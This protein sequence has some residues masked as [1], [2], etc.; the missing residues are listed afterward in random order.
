MALWDIPKKGVEKLG[1]TS[2]GQASK[3]TI[4]GMGKGLIKGSKYAGI[5]AKAGLATASQVAGVGTAGV[6]AG[7]GFV[8]LS[9]ASNPKFGLAMVILFIDFMIFGFNRGAAQLV[10][11]VIMYIVL[12]LIYFAW[13]LIASHGGSLK[14]AIKVFFLSLGISALQMAIPYFVLKYLTLWIPSVAGLIFVITLMFSPWA[15][16]YLFLNP[17]RVPNWVFRFIKIAWVIILMVLLLITLLPT[18]L[19]A[20]SGGVATTTSLSISPGEA[21]TDFKG[22][23][24]EQFESIS[25]KI[26]QLIHGPDLEGARGKIDKNKNSRLGVFIKDQ[27]VLETRVYENKEFT[28][29]G[30]LD[31]NTYFN[32]TEIYMSCYRLKNRDKKTKVVGEMDQIL[33]DVFGRNKEIIECKIPGGEKGIYQNYFEADFDFETWAYIDYT[34]VDRS[35]AMQYYREGRDINKELSIETET[36]PV[37]TDGPVKIL[38]IAAN[39]P[40]EVDFDKEKFPKIGLSLEKNYDR[41]DINLV[42]EIVI[43]TPKLVT[44]KDCSDGQ[45][46]P[47][48][49]G[50]EE[51]PE[52]FDNS[53]SEFNHYKFINDEEE[54]DKLKIMVCSMKLNQEK[55][56][57]QKNINSKLVKTILVRASYD[58]KVISS[59]LSQTIEKDPFEA[60]WEK[61]N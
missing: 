41:G 23:I 49:L 10:P 29:I 39:Q 6:L 33:Y 56:S 4:E 35:L 40:V 61:E 19:S 26:N 18:V 14:V 57:K 24:V 31:V 55:Y 5:Q 32:P 16:Y 12:S 51:I 11:L 38:M 52:G 46:N 2:L 30:T 60:R 48:L 54:I 42:R 1:K 9:L 47:E 59:G 45:E 13:E 25:S 58:Y 15:V 22:F 27:K 37:Y 8:G 21:I 28:M 17:P 34:F 50:L 53:I 20:V 43:Q 36:I 3:K 44:L 7:V